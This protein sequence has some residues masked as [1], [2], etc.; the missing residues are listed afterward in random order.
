MDFTATPSPTINQVVQDFNQELQNLKTEIRK[1]V[2]ESPDSDLMPRARAK[3]NDYGLGAEIRDADLRTFILEAR[4][5]RIGIAQPR[6]QGEVIDT[7]P[8][9]WVWEGVMMAGSLN[10]LIAPPKI[11]KSA[12]MIG[13]IAA[14]ARGDGSYLGQPLHGDCPNV[15]IVG[16]D[17]PESDWFTLLQREGLVADGK[18]LGDPIKMLWSAGAPLHLSAEGIEHLRMVSESDPGSLFLIDSYHACISP[19][20]IDEASSA[21]DR[22]ARALME[23][24]GPSKATVALI[25]HANKS[26]SGGNATSASRGS[27]ALPAAA[28]LTILMNWLKQPTEGQTQTD[29]RVILKTQGRARGCSLVTELQDNGWVLHGEG[30]E[31]LRAEAFANAEAELSGRQ[32]DVFDFIAERW[33]AMQMPVSIAELASHFSMDRNKANRAVRQLE[34]KGLVRQAGSSETTNGRPS[35]LFAPLSPPPSGVGQTS[36]TE[37]TPRARIEKRGLSPFSPLSHML[38]GGSAG[39]T[40][41]LCHTPP[42]EPNASVEL[43]Q[44][45]GSWANGWKLHKDSTVHAITVWRLDQGSHLVKRSGLRWDIDVRLSGHQ[46]PPQPA[47]TTPQ[48]LDY[49]PAAEHPF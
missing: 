8:V 13:M 22:P 48:P 10:L 40:N 14:W 38:G 27:N 23:A 32:A 31:A 3:A 25:H 43:L 12:L 6:L 5:A 7:T 19:L 37:Q 9:R 44:P 45:D 24:L 2:Q 49:D 35:L 21:L 30:D 20:D 46:Q 36:Q 15:Y 34:R 41:P 11:G 16:T 29:T 1:L 28:S 4:G 18:T 17:Q 26:V 39:A 33:E 42:L 47:P